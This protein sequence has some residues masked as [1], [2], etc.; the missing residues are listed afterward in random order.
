MKNSIFI[1]L[2]CFVIFCLMGSM[3]I[4][5]QQSNEPND[6]NKQTVCTD[7]RPQVCTMDYRPVCAQLED[8]SFKTYSNGCTACSDPRVK[9]YEEGACRK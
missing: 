9:F 6:E 2:F 8:T 1:R 4:A 3:A 7:P 5:A